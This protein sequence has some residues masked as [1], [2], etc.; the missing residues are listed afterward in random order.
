MVGSDPEVYQLNTRPKPPIVNQRIFASP[1]SQIT[2]P[3]PDILC[4]IQLVLD[5]RHRQT[6]HETL[7][8]EK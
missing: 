6:F 3:G 8:R 5:L 2:L 7:R 4:P 1:V